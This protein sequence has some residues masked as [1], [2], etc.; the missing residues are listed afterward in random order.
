MWGFGQG[1]PLGRS[2]AI[3]S[4]AIHYLGFSGFSEEHRSGWSRAVA[5]SPSAPGWSVKGNA[6]G[7]V[8]VGF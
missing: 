6:P 3:G 1:T 2:W 8:C 5:P 7:L 4:L